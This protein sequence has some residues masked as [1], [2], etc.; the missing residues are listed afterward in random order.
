MMRG[1]RI[2]QLRAPPG[3]QGAPGTTRFYSALEDELMRL[4]GQERLQKMM[5]FV[6]FTDETPIEAGIL[7]RSIENA[8]SKVE[9]HNYEIRKQVL[10]YDDVM[11]KQR[12]VIYG[13]R[14]RVL[15]GQ[16]LRDFFID[17][18]RDKVDYAVD[19]GAPEEKHP[20][21]WDLSATLDELELLFPIKEHVT[22]EELEKLDR[23]AMKE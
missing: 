5:D 4:F 3:R 19:T 18:L 13:E 16:P 15:E 22:V 23:G 1:A 14:R 9:N 7:S 10:E 8:Q 12:E 2:N 21:E 20:S 11:N 6:K 17:T